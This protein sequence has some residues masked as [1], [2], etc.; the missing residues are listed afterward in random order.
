MAAPRVVLFRHAPV[1]ID[2]R[3]KKFA[4]TLSRGGY[5]P[6]IISLEAAGGR[7][8]EY[9]LG[10]GIRVIRVPLTRRPAQPGPTGNLE[11]RRAAHRRRRVHRPHQVRPIGRFRP[12]P[13]QS[14][15]LPP[16]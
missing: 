12:W 6:I 5:E 15:P 7:S 4:T 16:A 13:C 10:D 11:A 2:S 3:V 1:D 14:F 8:G 9:V